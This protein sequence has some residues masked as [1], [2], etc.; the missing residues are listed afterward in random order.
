ME[1]H[2]RS[3]FALNCRIARVVSIFLSLF[4][5]LSLATGSFLCHVYCWHC[6]QPLPSLTDP[7]IGYLCAGAVT[8]RLCHALVYIM[9]IYT[10]MCTCTKRCGVSGGD[11][12][13]V[14]L[15]AKRATLY[16]MYNGDVTYTRHLSKS[17][18]RAF[19]RKDNR[20]NKSSPRDPL[21]RL[22]GCRVRGPFGVSR[23]R[24][25]ARLTCCSR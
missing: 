9:Y 14:Y 20:D 8:T 19:E 12:T 23:R 3:Q 24:G 17:I 16:E 6:H 22:R 25:G 1:W 2:G 11:R 5:S 15:Y 21:D 7:K 10:C 13:D 18:R 4:L